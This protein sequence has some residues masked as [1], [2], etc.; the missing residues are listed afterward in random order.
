MKSLVKFLIT[1]I[2]FGL[3][4]SAPSLRAQDAQKKGGR[5]GATPE[6]QIERLETAVGK[7]TEKQVTAIK[8]IYVKVAADMQ[9]LPQE[10]RRGGKGQDMRTAANKEVRALLTDEQA[11]KFDE[12][13]QGGRGGGGGG[14][15]KNQ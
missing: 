12:M 4:A 11:K 13:P 3:M 2:A 10:D 5:G 15:K 14:K 6:Q 8:A 7:L 9:A 1:A